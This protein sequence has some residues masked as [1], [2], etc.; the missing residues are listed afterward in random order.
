MPPLAETIAE[1]VPVEQEG[2]A[3]VVEL[4]DG[5]LELFTIADVAAVQPLLSVIVTEYEFAERK[6]YDTPVDAIAPLLPLFQV[7]LYPG[8]PPLTHTVILPSLFPQLA[9]VVTGFKIIAGGCKT[10]TTAVAVLA[11]LSVMVTV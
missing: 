3:G 10:V 6:T 2:F 8:V 4:I 11:A 1:P 7:K 9:G 5:P